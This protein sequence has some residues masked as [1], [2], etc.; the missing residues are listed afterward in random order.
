LSETVVILSAIVYVCLLFGIATY[1]DRQKGS[2]QTARPYVYALSLAIYC[3]SWT[4]F[5]SVGL[6]AERGIE[7]LGIYIGPVLVFTFGFKFLRRVIHLAKSER[8]TSHG[9][10][11]LYRHPIEGNFWLV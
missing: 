9:C 10:R 4:F 8:I 7:Y 1:G 2:N 3:T 5:G 11:A 6:A